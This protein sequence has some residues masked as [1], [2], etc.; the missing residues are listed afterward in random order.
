MTS[1]STGWCFAFA[2]AILGACSDGSTTPTGP[3]GT[4][5]LQALDGQALPQPYGAGTTLHE[6]QIN[7]SE[8]PEFDE[9][10]ILTSNASPSAPI[11]QRFYGVWL[12]DA[13]ELTFVR[14][15]NETR[16]NTFSTF[17]GTWSGDQLLVIRD[18]HAWNYAR[19]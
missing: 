14:P 12:I 8:G 11:E 6:D 7:I 4:W 17:T 1:R 3:A 13:D 19:Q 16:G 5:V 2:I 18:G 9:A 15:Q 10:R